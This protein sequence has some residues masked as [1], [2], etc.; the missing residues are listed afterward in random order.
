MTKRIHVALLLASTLA[1]AHASGAD[2]MDIYRLA[3]DNDPQLLEAEATRRA[4]EENRPQAI[5]G[6]LPTVNLQGQ[7][8]DRDSDGITTGPAFVG[9]GVVSANQFSDADRLSW[10]L[11]L[12]QPLFRWDRWVA[13]KRADKQIALEEANYAAARQALAV[14]VAE[15]YFAVLGAQDTLAAEQANKEAI[16]RQLEEA[17][18]R[19]DV[20]LIAVTDVY[21]SR[22]AYDQSVAAEIGAKRA[23]ATALEN[24][25]EVTGEYAASDL[26]A[27]GD[28][29]PLVTPEPA[30]QET[31]VREAMNQN[32]TVAANRLQVDIAGDDIKSQRTG[33][34]PTLDLVVQRDHF[35]SDGT[36]FNV[37]GGQSQGGLD[38]SDFDTDTIALQ[39]SVPIFNGGA[40]RSRVRQAVHQQRAAKQRL[41][42]VSRETER[43]TRDAYL[44]VEAEIARVNALAQAV[45]SS[46][47]ALEA[48]EAG[49]DVGTRTS[50]DVLNARRDLFQAQTNFRAARYE[51]LLN[52]VRLKQ[53]AG[54]LTLADLQEINRWLTH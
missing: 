49:F 17:E 39:F 5:A 21:E 29:L 42:R 54:T 24:L 52:V 40:V 34:Y 6:L 37:V 47:T 15:R 27:P 28:D 11:Q 13:L 36:R 45:T 44:G 22:S 1:T 7:W 46:E 38:Q 19:F 31:W 48:T 41:E 20:G 2:L 53:A 51:Y 25:R 30:D 8:D 14:R 4:A 10:T 43:A 3:L 32:L 16:S 12:S 50:V 33:H 9:A 18:T 26:G 35:D 23:L